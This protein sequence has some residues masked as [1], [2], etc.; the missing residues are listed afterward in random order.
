MRKIYREFFYQAEF[1]LKKEGTISLLLLRGFEMLEQE[2]KTY[3]FS[4]TNKHPV[5]LGKE[6]W[7]LVTLRHK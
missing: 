1:V 3:K 4:I 5:W 7:K 2:A 6:E